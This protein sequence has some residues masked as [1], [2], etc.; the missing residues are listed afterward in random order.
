[1]SDLVRYVLNMDRTEHGVTVTAGVRGNSD[2][3][4]A[5]V[6]AA[7]AQAAAS[8]IRPGCTTAPVQGACAGCKCADALARIEAH[9]TSVAVIV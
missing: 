7:M 5:D 1:M 3:S 2:G 9:L 8:V 4:V 6:V